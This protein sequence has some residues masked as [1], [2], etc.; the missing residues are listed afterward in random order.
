MFDE[1]ELKKEM[2]KSYL[3]LLENAEEDLLT[4]CSEKK[5]P[6]VGEIRIFNIDPPFYLL[7]S[8]RIK[9]DLY[10]VIPFTEFWNLVSNSKISL[11]IRVKK[12]RLTLSPLPFTYYFSG[13]LL[14]K[15]SCVITTVEGS[16]V[17]TVRE[18]VGKVT[19]LDFDEVSVDFLRKESGRIGKFFVAS[20]FNSFEEEDY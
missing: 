6:L 13:E 14:T 17:E 1:N 11:L 4:E 8:K 9:E 3:E 7:V 12:Y 20:I 19:L 16:V 15:Y 18:Y 2:Y 5:P 10:E